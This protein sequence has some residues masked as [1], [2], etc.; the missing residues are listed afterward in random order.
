MTEHQSEP[1]RRQRRPTLT[2]KMLAALPRKRKRYTVSDPEQRGLYIRVPPQGPST[3]SVVA[4]DRYKKQIWHTVGS[5]DVL[6]IEEARDKA[7]AAI[8][9]I[10][11]GKPPVEPTPAKPD[12]FESVAQDW[13]K[14]YVA[15]KGLRTAGEIGRCLKKYVYPRWADR[16]FISIRR[17]DITKLLDHIQD[18]HGARQADAVLAI[19]RS[20]TNWHAKR[21]DDYVSPVVRGTRRVDPKAR[22][23]ARILTDAELQSVW[24]QA[25]ANGA[26]GA[27]IRLLLLTGQ[28]REKVVTMKWSDVVD[29]VWTIT[30]AAREKGNAG[31]LAL[32]KAAIEIIAQQPRMA[33][34]PYVFAGR[35]GEAGWLDISQSKRPFDAKLPP[36][37]RWV[38]H[39]LRRT[40][41]SLLSRCGV[42]PDIAERV[43]G[44]AI[45]GIGATYD[46]YDYSDEKADALRRL[47]ALIETIIN[48]PADN[49][50]QLA[51]R[52]RAA[53]S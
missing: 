27:V 43:L 13:F 29:G 48:P 34:N 53:K 35:R 7:R 40:S 15:E 39:D 37:P 14:R 4:R 17:S 25:E 30:T 11:E 5:A 3:F 24:K 18:N 2:D 31:A 50:R 52:R 21:V 49:V 8:K 41:R 46:H 20:I 32:P 9:R 51:M 33:G 1:I 38:L 10:K 12:S 6:T 47:A 28:R 44:H 19:V 16:D 45:P 23:R 42:R 22:T 26:F 36:M